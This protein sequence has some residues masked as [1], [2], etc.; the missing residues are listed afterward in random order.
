MLVNSF[1]TT[2]LVLNLITL[3]QC[4]K[5]ETAK[6]QRD[7]AKFIQLTKRY[8][9]TWKYAI[10]ICLNPLLNGERARRKGEQ[11][12]NRSKAVS[13]LRFLHFPELRNCPLD[14]RWI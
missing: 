7:I 12:L 11:P 3:W 2:H 8:I 13:Q 5:P 4:Q 10:Y 14:Q 9:P 1:L 6:K